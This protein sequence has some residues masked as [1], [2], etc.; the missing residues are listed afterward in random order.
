[1]RELASSRALTVYALCTGRSSSHHQT[2]LFHLWLLSTCPVGPPEC[3]YPPKF[4]Y[5][6]ISLRPLRLRL[7]RHVEWSI[8]LRRFRV[9]I[10]PHRKS[11]GPAAKVLVQSLLLYGQRPFLQYLPKHFGYLSIPVALFSSPLTH[12]RTGLMMIEH[13]QMIAPVVS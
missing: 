4:F 1:M 5:R 12:Y 13:A 2:S 11:V 9:S 6:P 10:L 3:A 8:L 7:R